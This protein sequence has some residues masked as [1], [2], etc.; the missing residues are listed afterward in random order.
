MA[1][2]ERRGSGRWRARYRDPSGRERSKT[3][4]RR[5][6]AERF[7]TTIEHSKLVGGYIDPG[8]GRVTFERFS[9]RWLES[10][11]FDA[12][13]HEALESRLRVHLLPAFG[14]LELRSIRPSTIQSWLRGTQ[15]RCAPRSTRVLLANLSAILRAAVEDDLIPRNPCASRAVRAPAVAPSRV[16]PWPAEQVAAVIASHPERWRAAP[17]VAAGCGLRQGEVFGLRVEDVDFLGRQ[18]HVR[19]QVK[20]LR[21]QPTLA[22]PKGRKTRDVPLPDAVAMALAERL[23]QFP[24]VDGLVFTS[25]EHKLVNRTYFNRH[26]WK[27]ALATAGV[28]PTRENGMHALRHFYASALLEA[29]TSIRAVADY[30]G[31]QDPGFTLRTYTHLMPSSEDRVRQA[32]DAVLDDAPATSAHLGRSTP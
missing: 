11:T 29:G 18:L 12:S 31:H 30:L 14:D 3:F 16:I 32:I 24:A 15:D 9:A 4:P 22:P 21:G 28:A 19:Q 23:R 17:V 1:H 20:L 25:R 8:A 2:I 10:Q 26:V 27:A 7:L 5:S 13:T 6:D